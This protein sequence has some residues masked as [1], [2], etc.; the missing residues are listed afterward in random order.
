[1]LGLS[2]ALLCVKHVY[3]EGHFVFKK[4]PGLPSLG[5]AGLNLSPKPCI[6]PLPFS[7]L[8]CSLQHCGEMLACSV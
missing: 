8:A 1:M 5:L 2:P 6:F 3:D 4:C 7:I